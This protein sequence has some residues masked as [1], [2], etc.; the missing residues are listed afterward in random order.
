MEQMKE[1]EKGIKKQ[2]II[3]GFG[4][5][6]VPPVGISSIRNS[7]LVSQFWFTIQF[8]APTIGQSNHHEIW[9]DRSKPD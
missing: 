8:V 5:P 9:E 1:I 6:P 3:E 2:V 7:H 4:F